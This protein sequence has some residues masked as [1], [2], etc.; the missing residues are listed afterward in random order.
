MATITETTSGS[1]SGRPVVLQT[2]TDTE[3]D[4][5]LEYSV[6]LSTSGVTQDINIA[7]A[8]D[9]SGSA[10]DPSGVD[11]D[12]DGNE[13][14]ILEVQIA[15]AKDLFQSFLDAGYE[16][17]EIEITLVAYNGSATS[18][19]TFD[20][21]E[22]AGF[23]AAL[24]GLSPG[25]QTNFGAALD[26]VIAVWDATNTDGDPNNDVTALDTN[27]VIFMSDGFSNG[28]KDF[29]DE[30]AILEG[31]YNA[32][33]SAL[34]IGSGSSLADLDQIDNTGGAE[35]ITDLAQVSDAIVTPPPPLAEL[36]QVEVFIDGVSYGVYTPGDGTLQQTPLGFTI[37]NGVLTGYPY[38]PGDTLDFD[39]V[40]T[41]E[42]GE[43]VA[44]THT[45]LMPLLVCFAEG[46]R[47]RTPAGERPVESL[48]VGDEV[49]TRGGGAAPLLWIGARRL[50]AADLRAAP[51]LC[52]IRIRAGAF[53]PGQ[54][55]RDLLL[56]RQHRVYLNT[57]FTRLLFD[58]D[59]GVLA[60]AHALVNGHSIVQD[61]PSGAL[62]YWHLAFETHVILDTQGLG[63]ESLRPCGWAVGAMPQEDRSEIL[64]LFPEIAMA[65]A[66]GDTQAAAM[67]PACRLLTAG[68]AR[69]L[70]P[71]PPGPPPAAKLRATGR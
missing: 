68:E 44:T 40:A 55:G 32:S 62:T 67:P 21:T 50:S 46:T 7:I 1:V 34:G 30:M 13:D 23:D 29:S 10:D 61:T 49:C 6:S 39:V 3:A 9:I 8:I 60:P 35:Q 2:T 59:E 16:A 71:F 11:I 37:S 66:R 43:T 52:P 47:V 64:A 12:G 22:Q 58:T 4:S 5:T 41:F 33:V 69:L 51:K 26:Q 54:P 20:M 15:A 63:T 38:N 42:N 25:G 57:W 53:G 14:T 45:V 31:T 28:D 17:D 27:H 56:T 19:G 70:V 65:L 48:R 36:T 24:S 18:L